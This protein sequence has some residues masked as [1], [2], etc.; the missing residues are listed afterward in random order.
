VLA[1][2]ALAAGVT[3]AVFATLSALGPHAQLPAADAAPA[4]HVRRGTPPQRFDR[5]AFRT[6]G[7]SIRGTAG[8]GVVAVIVKLTGKGTQWATLEHGAFHATFPKGRRA[9]RVVEVLRGGTRKT[10]RVRASSR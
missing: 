6:D 1:V 3:A 9:V 7:R 8:R 5:L 4:A 10:A 2:C